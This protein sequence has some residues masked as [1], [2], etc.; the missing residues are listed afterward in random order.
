M[1]RT[2]QPTQHKPCSEHHR[3]DT[4][5]A[6]NRSMSV[7]EI[8]STYA[9]Y[10][11]WMHR[12]ELFD[13]VVT[14]RY[15]RSR[16]GDVEGRVLD[17][18]CGA[19]ANFRYLPDTVDLVG[20]DISPEMLANAD[21]QLAALGMD[22]TLREMDAQDLDFPDD[23]FDVVISALSTCTFPNPV[24][25]LREM[26]RVCKPDG[27]IRLVEHGRS[28][29]GAIAR[30]QEWRTDAHYAKM[31]CRWTQEPREIVAEAGLTVQDTNT[32]L[33]GMITT[34]EID[35]DCGDRR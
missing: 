26:E 22:G 11:D 13:R 10:A 19:G 27:T 14:G 33:L 3:D 12:F 21:E 15:R 34:F 23:S 35:P 1:T 28:D 31:G 4:D 2:E 8:K 17:V 6:S 16:F 20:I 25:A 9:E 5:P 29:V 32:G 24:A 30:Y 7:S 18:A